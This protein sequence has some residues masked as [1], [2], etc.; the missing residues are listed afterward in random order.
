MRA[1][2]T[3]KASAIVDVSMGERWVLG[4]MVGSEDPSIAVSTKPSQHEIG[5][6][7]LLPAHGDGR[8]QLVDALVDD[9]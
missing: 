4:R 9:R 7:L 1:H 5:T 8:G 2:E 6:E 3:A